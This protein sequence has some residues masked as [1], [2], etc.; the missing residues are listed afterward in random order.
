M[1]FWT[2]EQLSLPK[3]FLTGPLSPS[4]LPGYHAAEHG[5]F[6]CLFFLRPW[7]AFASSF[8]FSSSYTENDLNNF[9]ALFQYDT[10]TTAF[11]S[12]VKEK[13]LNKSQKT[14]CQSFF[15]L[16]KPF[17]KGKGNFRLKKGILFLHTYPYGTSKEFNAHTQIVV[18]C[19]RVDPDKTCSYWREDVTDDNG[20]PIKISTKHLK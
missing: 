7:Q 11:I 18:P 2:C 6:V 9:L 12:Y 19:H 8:H 13:K 20:M 14:I 4:G 1:G 10:L 17:W 5:N 15:W 3:G 16:F